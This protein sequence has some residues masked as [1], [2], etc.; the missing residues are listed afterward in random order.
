[1]IGTTGD[2]F[3]RCSA[4]HSMNN[5]LSILTLTKCTEEETFFLYLKHSVAQV[6][7][8]RAH[9]KLAA[10]PTWSFLAYRQTL[11]KVKRWIGL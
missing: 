1:M 8:L 9:G 2:C 6:G 3:F 5:V 10:A 7:P 11:K 4:L